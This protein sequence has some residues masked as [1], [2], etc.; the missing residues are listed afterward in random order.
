MQSSTE[1]YRGEEATDADM[2]SLEDRTN[3]DDEYDSKEE[4]KGPAAD[5]EIKLPKRERK[6]MEK[7]ERISN[8]LEVV[9]TQ[10]QKVRT[11][12]ST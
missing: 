11:Y 6:L 10:A 2:K 7:M 5:S 12:S 8:L 4:T 1:Q 9:E 3:Q